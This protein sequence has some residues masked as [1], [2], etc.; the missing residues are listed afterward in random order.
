MRGQ[1]ISFGTSAGTGDRRSLAGLLAGA[2]RPLDN[3]VDTMKTTQWLHDPGQTG[4]ALFFDQAH[5]IPDSTLKAP[6]EHRLWDEGAKAFLK[7][8]HELVDVIGFTSAAIAK[9]S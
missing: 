2:R 1:R 4:E 3:G 8:W 5:T 9:V 6:G 7:S